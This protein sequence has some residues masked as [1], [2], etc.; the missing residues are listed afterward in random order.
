MKIR[1]KTISYAAMKKKKT[2]EEEFRLQQDIQ[3]LDRKESKSEE[4][5][6]IIE[7]EKEQLKIM[8]EKRIEG[9]LIRS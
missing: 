4:E 2:N 6:K 5:V 1:A 3:Q 7:S 8:R 9:V